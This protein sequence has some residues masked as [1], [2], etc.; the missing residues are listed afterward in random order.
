MNRWCKLTSENEKVY[1]K[2]MN[3]SRVWNVE[4]NIDKMQGKVAKSVKRVS[5]EVVSEIMGS[6]PED[7]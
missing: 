6:R 5:Q 2:N 7:K 3:E 4:E 1:T